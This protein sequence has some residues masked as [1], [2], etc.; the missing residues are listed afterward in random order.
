M[1]TDLPI[2]LHGYKDR[3]GGKHP[4]VSKTMFR[5]EIRNPKF[6]NRESMKGF[7]ITLHFLMTPMTD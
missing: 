7:S 2:A 3:H 5:Y 6:E 1:F 4:H